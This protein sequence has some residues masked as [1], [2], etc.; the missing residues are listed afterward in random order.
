M[1][2]HAVRSA[3]YALALAA[4]STGGQAQTLPRMMTLSTGSDIATWTVEPDK[5]RHQTPIIYLHGGPGMYTEVRRF[6]EG[7]PL[8][9]AGFTTL[10]FDQAG[11]GQSKPIAPGD[12]SVERALADLEALRSQLGQDKIILWGNSY[13]ASLATLYASRFPGHVAGLILTSPGAFPGTSPKRNYAVTNR[14]KVIFTKEFQAAVSSIDS[15]GPAAVAEVSQADAGKLFDVAIAAE[16]MEAMVCK[17]TQASPPALQ[18]GGNLYANR[19][20]SKSLS[21]V[22]FK[23]K[24]L[25]AMPTL[26]LRGTCDFLPDS[27]AALYGRLFGAA[28]TSV[29]GTGHGFL[30][31]RAA[32]EAALQGFATG[33]LAS[34]N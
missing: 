25:P 14:D 1:T 31:N 8:R 33:P 9:A 11:G 12:Y 29:P 27:N 34:V 6:A 15:K 18:G 16:L 3:C 30:E 10:Y 5:K 19:L 13:G 22:R 21:K 7:E 23:P 28:V 2:M 32:I 20:V 4:F 17:G 26:I 24:P